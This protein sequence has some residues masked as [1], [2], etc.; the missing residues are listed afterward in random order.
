[1]KNI[2]TNR[3]KDTMIVRGTFTLK[4]I[5]MELSFLI[6]LTFSHRWTQANA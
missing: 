4:R 3:Q 6:T 5:H 1:M 2:L